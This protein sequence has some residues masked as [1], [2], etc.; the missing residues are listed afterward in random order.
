MKAVDLI[1]LPH[2]AVDTVFL[3]KVRREI[4]K[5]RNWQTG[6]VPASNFYFKGIISF[7]RSFPVGKELL[8]LNKIGALLVFPAIGTDEYYLVLH[9]VLQGLG[10]CREYRV[11]ASYLVAHLPAGLEN[12]VRE[13]CFVCHKSVI[14]MFFL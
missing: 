14:T 1:K 2:L 13:H 5:N 6:N 9:L 7:G 12:V 11:N 4:N 8:V 10:S 3:L